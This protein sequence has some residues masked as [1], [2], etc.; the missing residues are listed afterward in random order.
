MNEIYILRHLPC[1]SIIT[2]Y[3]VYESR[4]YIHLVLEYLKGGELFDKVMEKGCYSES[5]A[6]SLMKNIM[7]SIA[8]F[9]RKG[10]LHRDL[11]LENI[12]LEYFISDYIEKIENL[13][14]ITAKL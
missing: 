7:E 5:D 12:I 2:L 14:T 1:Q 11:K 3:D 8:S 10:I 13:P 9:H 4:E 6:R